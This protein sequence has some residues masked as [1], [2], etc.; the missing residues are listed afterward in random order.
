[1]AACASSAVEDSDAISRV[2]GAR[3]CTGVG[4]LPDRFA[5]SLVAAFTALITHPPHVDTVI[6]MLDVR[7]DALR[8]ML[9]DGRVIRHPGPVADPYEFRV[10]ARVRAQTR[11]PVRGQRWVRAPTSLPAHVPVPVRARQER[12]RSSCS[13]S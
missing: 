9:W 11:T 13:P 10:W 6:S 12:A 2:R 3:G 8:V 4:D 1:K 7:D 5:Q